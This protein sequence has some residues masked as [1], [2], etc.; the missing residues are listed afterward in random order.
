MAEEDIVNHFVC[1][2]GVSGTSTWYNR[3]TYGNIKQD[4]CHVV[5]TLER[6]TVHGPSQIATW[7]NLLC[8]RKKVTYVLLIIDQLAKDPLFSLNRDHRTIGC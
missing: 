3:R 7:I 5:K 6:E 8:K 2:V 1:H 4:V